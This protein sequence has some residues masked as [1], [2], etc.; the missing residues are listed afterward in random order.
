MLS[1]DGKCHRYGAGADGFVPGEGVGTV[2]LKP[3]GRAIADQDHIYA[4]ILGSAFDHSGRSNGYSAPNPNS[5][6][7]LISRALEKA[8]VHPE[9]IG[10]IEGHG[11]GTQLGDSIE[12]AALTKA[13]RKQTTKKEFCPIGSVKANVGHSE[14]AAGM[15]SLAKGIMQMKHQQLAPSIHSDEVNP[16]IEFGES[17][18]YLQHG[19][20]KWVSSF[21]R[22]ALINSFGAGGV[23]ACLNV[24]EYRNTSLSQDARAAGPYVFTV[25]AKNEERLREYVHRQLVHLR[26]EPDID[27]GNLCYTLQVGR[28][29]MEERLA[30]VVSNLDELINRLSEWSQRQSSADVYRGSLGPRRG[31]GR[32]SKVAQSVLREGSLRELASARAA[33]EDVKWESLYSG[34][35]P[36]RIGLPTYPF[37]R[38][39][40]WITDSPIPERPARSNAQLHPLIGYNSSSLKEV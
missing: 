25:S 4:V 33:G 24:E 30:L 36:R 17:P 37:A 22:R 16:D 11:T 40:Y 12:I 20:S 5:Q 31:S 14:S 29:A 38:E 27:L 6:A 1:L 21:P 10:Y 13:F 2:V 19:L 28:E 34:T 39:R 26:S 18:F 32:P 7:N 3:L 35:R 23:N 8:H 9:T 15:A